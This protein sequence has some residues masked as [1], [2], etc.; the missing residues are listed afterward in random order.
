MVR[1][2]VVALLPRG[3]V[4][5]TNCGTL[6]CSMVA[7]KKEDDSDI[8]SLEAH[9]PLLIKCLERY[10][11]LNRK[12]LTKEQHFFHWQTAFPDIWDNWE[13]TETTGGFDAIIGNPPWDRM[14]L[15]EVEWFAARRP[16]I[17]HQAKAAD[18]KIMIKALKETG[19]PLHDGYLI[20]AE[21]AKSAA[22]VAQKSGQYPLL[23][24]GDIN[25]YSLFV[26][27]TQKLVKPTGIVGLLVPSGIASDKSASAFFKTISTKGRLSALLDFENK[28]AFFPDVHA[29]FKFCALIA[30]GIE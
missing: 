24:K 8:E 13:S 27:R 5:H 29:S 9:R 22:E 4:D 3:S 19:D 28:K 26:E 11:G 20:A 1:A 21:R 15:Q 25:L 12:E 10:K 6:S 23:S 18:R 17:A 30:G 2:W 14:K 16:E 7:Q